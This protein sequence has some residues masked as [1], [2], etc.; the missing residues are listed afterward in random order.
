MVVRPSMP[1]LGRELDAAPACCRTPDRRS[2][3]RAASSR[4]VSFAVAS[5]S[6]AH[7]LGRLDPRLGVA[8]LL[9]GLVGELL[10]LAVRL[11]GGGCAA[12][13]A[14][15]SAS[16][17]ASASFSVAS[18]TSSSARCWAASASRCGVLDLVVDLGLDLL[19]LLLGIRLGLLAL[20]RTASSAA[21]C[22]SATRC[23]TRRASRAPPPPCGRARA[24]SPG[25]RGRSAPWTPARPRRRAPRPPGHARRPRGRASSGPRP[26]RRRRERRRP[27]P[28][29][30]FRPRSR[31]VRGR[32]LGRVSDRLRRL[33]RPGQQPRSVGRHLPQTR[34]GPLRQ[35]HQS[36]L[37]AH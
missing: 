23:L 32:G 21:F 7:P 37:P 3:A 29:V 19:L 9:L 24:R 36:P 14:A 15:S 33:E 11:L 20:A 35:R 10:R 25:A 2:P 12:A 17:R 4:A 5:D 18:S 22:A 31:S 1:M 26:S 16:R 34:P 8:C 30:T 6:L 27:P 13:S 28:R